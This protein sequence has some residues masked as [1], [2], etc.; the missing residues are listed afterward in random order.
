MRAIVTVIGKDHVGIIADVT[1]L[2]AQYGV[3]VLDISQTVLQEYFTM[4]MLVDASQCTVPF[5]DLARAL[6][7]AGTQRSLQIRAQ[8]EDI[9]N[10]MHRI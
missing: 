3:N 8:R 4:I 6:D 9:F 5:A 2:L 1:A 10:A 7:E